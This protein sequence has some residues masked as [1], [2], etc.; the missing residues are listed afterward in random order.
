MVED[1]G[2]EYPL[3]IDPMLAL[4]ATTTFSQQAK[5]TASDGDNNDFFGISVAI[6]GDTAVAGAPLDNNGDLSNQ[7]AAYVFTRSGTTWTEQQKLTAS[8]GKAN[9]LFGTSVAIDGDTVV[10]GAP[11]RRWDCELRRGL[12]LYAQRDDLDRATETHGLGRRGQ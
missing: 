6:D 2:A 7:G 9:D 10:A 5:L 11:W 4:Q 3:T 1:G 8:D 12:C